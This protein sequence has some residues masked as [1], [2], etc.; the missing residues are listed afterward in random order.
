MLESYFTQTDSNLA[1][2]VKEPLSALSSPA[3]Q[4]PFSE[5]IDGSS[6]APSLTEKWRKGSEAVI[7]CKVES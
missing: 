6:I 2:S 1:I 4:T 5:W 3:S 7:E